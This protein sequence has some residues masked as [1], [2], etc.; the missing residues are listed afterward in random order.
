MLS[1]WEH[2]LR[3]DPAYN[4]NLTLDQCDFGLAWPPRDLV[5]PGLASVRTDID[6][7]NTANGQC[8]PGGG[9]Y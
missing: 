8:T 3:N 2:A 4:P 6:W 1:R 7:H 5:E 9:R